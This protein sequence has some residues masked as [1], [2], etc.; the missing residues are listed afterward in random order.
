MDQWGDKMKANKNETK[1][2]CLVSLCKRGGYLL[3]AATM[4]ALSAGASL[5]QEPFGMPKDISEYLLA[6]PNMHSIHRGLTDYYA[7]QMQAI[8]TLEPIAMGAIGPISPPIGYGPMVTM[9]IGTISPLAGYGALIATPMF[10][11]YGPCPAWHAYKVRLGM[12]GR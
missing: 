1:N 12:P 10:C 7:A 6:M 2:S 11:G 4:L 5:A 3:G 9:P 8:G